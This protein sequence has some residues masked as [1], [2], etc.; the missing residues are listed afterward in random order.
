MAMLD[1]N[2]LYW[3]QNGKIHDCLDGYPLKSRGLGR[4][5]HPMQ[6]HNYKPVGRILNPAEK[7][8]HSQKKLDN[9]EKLPLKTIVERIM[10]SNIFTSP[11]FSFDG[12]VTIPR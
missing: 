3:H 10:L 1:I 2:Q 9:L 5:L 8:A 11:I 6:R 4:V 12:G 7:R